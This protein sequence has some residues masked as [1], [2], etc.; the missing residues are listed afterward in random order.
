MTYSIFGHKKEF[1]GLEPVPGMK[2]SFVPEDSEK[3]A[4]AKKIREVEWVPDETLTDEG[5]DFGTVR[6]YS[7]IALDARLHHLLTLS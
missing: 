6:V 2:V 4:T 1:G 7:I 3:G 5:R